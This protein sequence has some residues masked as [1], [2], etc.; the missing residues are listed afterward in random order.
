MR[1]SSIQFPATLAVILVLF[2]F[3]VLRLLRP[4]LKLKNPFPHPATLYFIVCLYCFNRLKASL[5]LNYSPLYSYEESLRNSLE[6][7]KNVPL[8]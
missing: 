1:L 8:T 7:Y 2:L 5:R 3:V 6:Y 4:I